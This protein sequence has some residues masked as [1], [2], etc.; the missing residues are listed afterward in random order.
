[1]FEKKDIETYF[2]AEKKESYW[3]VIIGILSELTA[4]VFFFFLHSTCFTGA[5]IPIFM[6]GSILGIVGYTVYKRSDEDR[7]R[8]VYAYDMN[9]SELKNVEWPRMQTVMQNFKLYRYL[10]IIF[11]LIGIFL[12]LFFY[13]D[14]KNVFWK[15]FGIGLSAMA[16]IALVVDYFAEQRGKIYFKGL[17]SFTQKS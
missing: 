12:L 11:L 6:I 3:F 14:A 13:A 10:E 1:M 2:L 7:K 8:N 16:L 4:L 15:G 9:P 5:A 17:T